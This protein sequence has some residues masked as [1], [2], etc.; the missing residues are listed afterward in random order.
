MPAPTKDKVFNEGAEI[1]CERRGGGPLLFWLQ[2]LWSD[3]LG[4]FRWLTTVSRY[5]KKDFSLT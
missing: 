1:Y 4:I 5:S 2:V 3:N